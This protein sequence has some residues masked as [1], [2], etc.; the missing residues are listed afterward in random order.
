MSQ[1]GLSP[2]RLNLRKWLAT[3]EKTWRVTFGAPFELE[4]RPL[5]KSGQY[6][7]VV[8]SVQP[9]ERRARGRP[10]VRNR[11]RHRRPKENGRAPRNEN[12]VLRE[13]ID[14]SSVFEEIVG[15]SKPMRQVVKQVEKVAPSDSTVLR[16][17]PERVRRSQEKRRKRM[18]MFSGIPN[19]RPC[20]RGA[21]S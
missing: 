11:N 19:A 15:S 12:L 16:A 9:A 17:K 7:L 10:L 8:E 4:M 6:R 5:S 18:G 20:R 1:H 13:E 3:R 14:L 2:R 21:N